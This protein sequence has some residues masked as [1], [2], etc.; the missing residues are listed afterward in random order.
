MVLDQEKLKKRFSKG[1]QKHFHRKSITEIDHSKLCYIRKSELIRLF[2]ETVI[3]SKHIIQI[4]G[5]PKRSEEAQKIAEAYYEFS[6]AIS[7]E[8]DKRELIERIA[9]A[10]VIFV[11]A[12]LI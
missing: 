8:L 9:I 6:F 11:L 10:I 7:K 1:Y 5:M 2:M 12:F 3:H 4:H